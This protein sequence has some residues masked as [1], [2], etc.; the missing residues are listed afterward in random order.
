MLTEENKRQIERGV[1]L[2]PYLKRQV[3]FKCKFTNVHMSFNKYVWCDFKLF[4]CVGR[5]KED[6]RRITQSHLLP[7]KGRNVGK[8]DCSPTVGLDSGSRECLSGGFAPVWSPDGGV[9]Q[10]WTGPPSLEPSNRV[11]LMGTLL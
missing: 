6:R 5:R 8:F 4:H 2:W 10:R 11:C 1:P 7:Y 9:G 3:T